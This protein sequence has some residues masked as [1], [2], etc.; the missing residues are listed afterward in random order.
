MTLLHIIDEV[1]WKTYNS[2]LEQGIVNHHLGRVGLDMAE[3]HYVDH[4]VDRHID[5]YHHA[6]VIAEEKD[7]KASHAVDGD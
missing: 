6:L 4:I 7:G 2:S 1:G 3:L 5:T